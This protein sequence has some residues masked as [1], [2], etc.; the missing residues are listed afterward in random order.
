[1]NC[2]FRGGPKDGEEICISTE[3][4]SQ[5]LMI[6]EI[7]GKVFWVGDEALPYRPYIEHIYVLN[8]T[9]KYDVYYEYKGED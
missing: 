5:Y 1:M 2:Y 8:S 7:R 3:K 6:P 4:P 9:D